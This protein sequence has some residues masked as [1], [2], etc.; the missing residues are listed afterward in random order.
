M[1]DEILKQVYTELTN[2][3]EE[4]LA[5]EKIAP[6]EAGITARN[7]GKQERQIQTPREF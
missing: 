5:Q 3:N 6:R 2:G 4:K 1:L 7:K